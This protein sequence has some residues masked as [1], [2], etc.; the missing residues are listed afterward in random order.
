MAKKFSCVMEPEGLLQRLLAPV[1]RPY[2]ILSVSLTPKLILS[3]HLC[4][5]SHQPHGP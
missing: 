5:C 4:L 3:S 2:S 1:I